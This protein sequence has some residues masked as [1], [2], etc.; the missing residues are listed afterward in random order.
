MNLASHVVQVELV[1]VE[2]RTQIVHN[3][4]DDNPILLKVPIQSLSE[5]VN[6]TSGDESITYEYSCVW[7]NAKDIKWSSSGCQ[8]RG[9]NFNEASQSWSVSCACTHLVCIRI[10]NC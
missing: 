9:L 8:Y 3:V 6:E 1:D 10:F 4:P 7:W 5:S 2:G